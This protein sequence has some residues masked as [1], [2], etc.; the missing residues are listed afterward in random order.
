MAIRV[1][2]ANAHNNYPQVI[3]GEKPATYKVAEKGITQT[4]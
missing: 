3:T 1:C 2:P 4:G